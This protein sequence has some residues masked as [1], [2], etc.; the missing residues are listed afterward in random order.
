MS[1]STNG[2]DYIYNV[3]V[4]HLNKLIVAA[5]KPPNNAKFK[6]LIAGGIAGVIKDLSI[7]IFEVKPSSHYPKMEAQMTLSG[8]VN[9]SSLP[10][11]EANFTA[12]KV[13]IIID[14]SWITLSNNT[15]GYTPPVI[16]NEPG[17]PIKI[18]KTTTHRDTIPSDSNFENFAGILE[19]NLN[20]H[21]RDNK[22]HNYYDFFASLNKFSDI[23]STSWMKPTTQVF[24]IKK[25]LYQNCLFSFC[26]MINGN[27]NKDI[28]YVDINSIVDGAN[29][30]LV[31][32]RETFSNYLVKKIF[33]GVES[34]FG[35][36]DE[37]FEEYGPHGYTNKK[38]LTLASKDYRDKDDKPQ[39]GT[40]EPHKLLWSVE[41]TYMKLSISDV[42]YKYDNDNNSV[43]VNQEYISK[44]EA[45]AGKLS[46]NTIE[47]LFTIENEFKRNDLQNYI[48]PGLLGLGIT[49][50]KISLLKLFIN[51]F[52]WDIVKVEGPK[53]DALNFESTLSSSSS[54]ISSSSFS[55]GSSRDDD[56][57]PLD[58]NNSR[59]DMNNS[60]QG[61]I[62]AT[63]LTRRR[64]Q[65]INT[66]RQE[67]ESNA[68]NE[69]P[70]NIRITT[71]EQQTFRRT[72]EIELTDTNQ[73]SNPTF[74]FMDNR[75]IPSPRQ[76]HVRSKFD[77]EPVTVYFDEYLKQIKKLNK[78][79]NE[80]REMIPPKKNAQA[81]NWGHIKI[82]ARLIANI[83]YAVK[84]KLEKVKREKKVK[85]FV[86]LVSASDVKELYK[87]RPAAIELNTDIIPVNNSLY[88]DFLV[89]T[90]PTAKYNKELHDDIVE[91]VFGSDYLLVKID[92]L[93]GLKHRFDVIRRRANK[94]HKMNFLKVYFD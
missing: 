28:G 57:N 30:S 61:L 18:L 31:I 88:G 46:V 54:S 38:K 64:T 93:D 47:K 56:E 60:R 20:T 67:G 10:P 25:D 7:T 16:Q 9:S 92:L 23:T 12:I 11:Y 51:D 73:N 19:T 58:T 8:H 94:K 4:E 29:S 43:T 3:N 22:A 63:R 48:F 82:E 37:D 83:T 13:N 5:S 86:K 14:M 68:R 72:A 33:H 91:E 75:N 41:H 35:G 34:V 78:A 44:F 53:T 15:G 71:K 36:T 70:S 69:T 87:L 1:F 62:E 65:P 81:S 52:N 79:S 77:E 45:N 90:T 74:G 42:T 85:E 80:L 40:I 89:N 84:S 59:E 6:G 24:S 26:C 32:S 21:I 50:L 39:S 27:K 17:H 2:W 76:I 49:S 55:S 66:G